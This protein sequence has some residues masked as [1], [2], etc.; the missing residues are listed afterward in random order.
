[1]EGSPGTRHF[2]FSIFRSLLF[3][4]SICNTYISQ[5]TLGIDFA[6]MN[7]NFIVRVGT[8]SHSPAAGQAGG[9][10]SGDVGNTWTAFGNQFAYGKWIE[11][12]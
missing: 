3:I 8:T 6:E 2:I 10:Y 11:R 7:P 5:N 12:R 9:F 4:G 1:M